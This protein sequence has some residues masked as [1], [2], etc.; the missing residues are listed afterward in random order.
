MSR[1]A[2]GRVSAFGGGGKGRR[3]THSIHFEMPL[4]ARACILVCC[5]NAT[6]HRAA[7]L[8]FTLLLVQTRA[9]PIPPSPSSLLPPPSNAC[10]LSIQRELKELEVEVMKQRKV[11]YYPHI[12]EIEHLRGR[13]CGFFRA[14]AVKGRAGDAGTSRSR[15]CFASLHHE[16]VPLPARTCALNP[17]RQRC[18]LRVNKWIQCAL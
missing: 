9:C 1:K 17:R 15:G 13:R 2:L 12:P 11:G 8:C 16:L 14:L 18:K 6:T 4:S 5:K 10:P 7:P 3:A